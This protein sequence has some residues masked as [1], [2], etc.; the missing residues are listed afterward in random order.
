MSAPIRSD[1]L[2]QAGLGTRCPESQAD[3]VPCAELGS[4]C[5]ICGRAL[6]CPEAHEPET[7]AGS[8]AKTVPQQATAR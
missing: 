7:T 3:G 6:P 2:A 4:D 1:A 8:G 5:A